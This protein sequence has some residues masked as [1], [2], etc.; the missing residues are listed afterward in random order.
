MADYF[1]FG[2]SREIPWAKRS[3]A[4][5]LLAA[6]TDPARGFDAIVIGEFERAFS[7]D[8]Y[9][10]S[11]P[12][13]D[14][15]GAGSRLPETDG[16]LDMADPSHR[17]ARSTRGGTT[18]ACLLAGLLLCALCHDRPG[19]R[20]RRHSALDGM[21]PRRFETKRTSSPMSPPASP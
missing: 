19:Y 20:C 4:A 5:A 13:L 18:R 9:S 17:P 2:A 21:S 15:C 1:D 14:A 8:Q 16:P 12:V 7:R 3:Q 10:A 11:A 6:L